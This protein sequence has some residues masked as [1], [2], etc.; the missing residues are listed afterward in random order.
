MIM[1][2]QGIVRYSETVTPLFIYDRY[3][4]LNSACEKR[5]S[6]SK[7]APWRQRH[8]IKTY[9]KII[10][11]DL[12]PLRDINANILCIYNSLRFQ[13]LGALTQYT[14]N[15]IDERMLLNFLLDIKENLSKI[16]EDYNTVRANLNWRIRSCENAIEIP[17]KKHIF[18]DLVIC[19]VKRNELLI[20]FYNEEMISKKN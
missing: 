2:P 4:G 9:Q 18:I 5:W 10:G 1:T 16:I 11:I 15:L 19:F 7:V 20:A 14:K 12:A 3:P 6:L 13:I 17:E 8:V